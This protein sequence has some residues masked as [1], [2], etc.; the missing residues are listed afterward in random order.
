M[1]SK[2]LILASILAAGLASADVPTSM[3][4]DATVALTESVG[5]SNTRNLRA[6]TEQTA[7]GAT[8]PISPMEQ[9]TMDHTAPTHTEETKPVVDGTEIWTL[10]LQCGNTG[11]ASIANGNILDLDV[12]VSLGAESA[13]ACCNACVNTN[14][15]IAFNFQPLLV[16]NACV[17]A[18]STN[19]EVE[20]LLGSLIS[21]DADVNLGNLIDVAADVNVGNLLDVD[22]LVNL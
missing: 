2:T 9:S 22:A 10:P 11:G 17:L 6:M 13:Q 21:V 12:I 7:L 1:F 15:C 16:I 19:D 8:T 4:H 20:G 5:A 3:Q 18:R 14:L